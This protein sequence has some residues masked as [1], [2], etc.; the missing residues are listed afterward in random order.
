M[1]GWAGSAAVKEM[2]IMKMLMREMKGG[3]TFSDISRK[4]EEYIT[5]YY[6]RRSILR[7]NGDSGGDKIWDCRA[8]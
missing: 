6:S 4:S 2:V 1:D 8:L 3:R 5:V 7:P